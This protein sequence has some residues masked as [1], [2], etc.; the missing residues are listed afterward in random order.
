M[1]ASEILRDII[2]GKISGRTFEKMRDLTCYMQHINYGEIDPMFMSMYY[3]ILGKICVARKLFNMPIYRYIIGDE[4]AVNDVIY[5]DTDN[6]KG[7]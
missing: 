4:A 2:K 3:E 5:I 1:M 7:V 6:I